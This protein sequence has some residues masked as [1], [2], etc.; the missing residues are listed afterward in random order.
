MLRNKIKIFELEESKWW[1]IEVDSSI[2]YLQFVFNLEDFFGRRT[3]L[4]KVLVVVEGSL[5]VEEFGWMEKNSKNGRFLQIEID[6]RSLRVT[7]F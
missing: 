1:R 6:G 2:K 7:N 5:M 3:F 4:H